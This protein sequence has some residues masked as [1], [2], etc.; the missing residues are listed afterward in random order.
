ML[1]HQVCT[2]QFSVHCTSTR[3]SSLGIKPNSTS[4]TCPHWSIYQ[5]KPLLI[6]QLLNVFV[7]IVL[8]PLVL[9]QQSLQMQPQ[10]LQC[11]CKASPERGCL[12]FTTHINQHS[13]FI[14]P[15]KAKLTP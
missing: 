6:T 5:V 2:P 13:H 14:P 1:E 9:R 11:V 3:Q 15:V 7:N 4:C 10:F 8:P 12:Y